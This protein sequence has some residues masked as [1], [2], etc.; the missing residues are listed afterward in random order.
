MSRGAVSRS[1]LLSERDATGLVPG[2]FTF[3]AIHCSYRGILF[4]IVTNV[5]KEGSR[6]V[7]KETVR[8]FVV[9]N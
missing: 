2:S 8:E 7:E 3:A 5:A 4:A 1:Q 6:T 9:L